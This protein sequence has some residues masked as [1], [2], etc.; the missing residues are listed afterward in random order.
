[1]DFGI[2]FE[3]FVPKNDISYH[4]NA[5]CI[6]WISKTQIEFSMLRNFQKDKTMAK[7]NSLVFV[8][9]VGKFFDQILL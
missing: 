5:W 3:K 9:F 7:T 8:P 2:V 1:M 4:R 6:N